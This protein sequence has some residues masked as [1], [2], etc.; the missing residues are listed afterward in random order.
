MRGID[1]SNDAA[2]TR[3]GCFVFFLIEYPSVGY[4]HSEE[5]L[6]ELNAAKD[7]S[8]SKTLKCEP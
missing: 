2:Q 8:T 4:N 6:G 7:G 5:M 1:P 3:E